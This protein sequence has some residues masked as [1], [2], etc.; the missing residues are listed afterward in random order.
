MYNSI[1]YAEI[2]Y[3]DHIKKDDEWPYLFKIPSLT[4]LEENKNSS[5]AFVEWYL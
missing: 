1:K 5:S 3:F 4:S 2:I